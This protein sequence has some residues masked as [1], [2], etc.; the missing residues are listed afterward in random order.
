M[1]AMLPVT[2]CILQPH[3]GYV[4][5]TGI[6]FKVVRKLNLPVSFSGSGVFDRF[7]GYLG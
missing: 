6:F 1:V 4:R 5:M 3:A 7:F 2:F